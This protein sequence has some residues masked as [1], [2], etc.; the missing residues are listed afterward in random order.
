MNE[1]VDLV[2][3]LGIDLQEGNSEARKDVIYQMAVAYFSAGLAGTV[4]FEFDGHHGK[5]VSFA[6][7]Q[8]VDM[9]LA[10]LKEPRNVFSMKDFE[11]AGLALNVAALGGDVF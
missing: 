2:D 10:N 3:V 8:E 6:I 9:A 1:S 5:P 11:E 7:D 4:V